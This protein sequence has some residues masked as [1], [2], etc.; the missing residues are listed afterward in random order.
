MNQG[1]FESLVGRYADGTPVEA[2]PPGEQRI[3]S[4]KDNLTRIFNTREGLLPH[5]KGYGLPDISEIYRTMPH[6]IERLE[7]AIKSS[8]E[9]YEP[10]LKNVKVIRLP[11][12]Q[13]KVLTIEFTVSGEILGIGRITFQTR[14]LS[15][16]QSSIASWKKQ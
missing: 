5:L 2:V 14:F 15:S 16:G 9:Q 3:A 10:R 8:I 12:T 1:L 11:Q 6:G 7:S 4:I 13:G